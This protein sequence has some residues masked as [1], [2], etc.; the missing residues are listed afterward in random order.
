MTDTFDIALRRGSEG[1]EFYDFLVSGKS[2]YDLLRG[3][4]SGCLW[5]GTS[6]AETVAKLT[7]TAAPDFP[8][9]KVAIYVCSEC[10]DINCGGKSVAIERNN[11][12]VSWSGFEAF[13]FVSGEWHFEP[14]NLKECFIFD[15][16]EYDDI[17][18]SLL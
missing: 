9:N 8:P 14:T 5:K 11:G 16:Q 2:L 3:T 7:H 1:P 13:F 12:E 17:L 15:A 6:L 4:H 10:G 18:R